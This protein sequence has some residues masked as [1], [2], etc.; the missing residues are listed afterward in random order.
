MDRE[1]SPPPLKRQRMTHTQKELRQ[2]QELSALE[3]FSWN[4][5]GISPFIQRPITSFFTSD[6]ASKAQPQESLRDFLRRQSFP[7]MLLL[8]EVK[9]NPSDM[10]SQSAVSRAVKRDASEPDTNPDYVTHFCLPHDAHNTTG[11]GRKVY[12]VCSIVRKDFADQYVERMRGVDWDA[13]G[14]FSIVE[15]KPGFDVPKMAIFNVYMIN[16]TDN[17]Y[18][19]SETGTVTG[20]RHKRK[21]AVHRLLQAEIRKSEQDGYH[22]IIAGDINIAVA[23]IDGHPNLRTFPHQ[24]VLNRQDFKSRFLGIDFL[25]IANDEQLGSDLSKASVGKSNEG[26]DMMDTFRS[27]HPD[28]KG[29]SYYPRGKTFGES[30][31]RVDMILCSRS[32][33]KRCTE[34]GML[35][36][37]A[38]RGTS[39]HVP[40][41]ATFTFSEQSHRGSSEPKPAPL[42]VSSSCDS[43]DTA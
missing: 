9:V 21:L 29:Y 7:T 30:C 23:P 31:D 13:E 19:D 38:D 26:L 42:L 22:A 14:R 28:Q 24:H 32:L 1:I 4:V 18:K 40:I 36:T 12:G 3:I 33:A 11:F 16:G 25:G 43:K 5:N 41:Y 34:A 35:A 8:Q 20:T 37:S 27:L 2:S 39:D 10:A 17:P 6:K 15:T